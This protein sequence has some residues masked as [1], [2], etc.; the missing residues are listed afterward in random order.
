MTVPAL[1]VRNA[2]WGYAGTPVV[3]VSEL[4]LSAGALCAV[5][6]ANGAGKSTLLSGLALLR[7]PL[8]GEVMVGGDPAWPQL[9]GADPGL[10]A[11]RRRVTLL[12]Q[13]PA[14][15]ST[16]VRANVAYGLRARGIPREEAHR[17]A[18]A[19]L[20]LMGLIELARRPARSLS[21]GET[22][23]M[24]IARAFVLGTPVLLLDE[25]F[26]SLDAA[27]R[28][29]LRELIAERRA[30]GTAVIVATHVGELDGLDID[31]VLEL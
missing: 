20:E 13:R 17:R 22:Q 5:V 16:D 18:D 7:P 29:L 30:A 15:F 26:S 1:Q 27:T 12:H 19:A 6:G 9:K 8:R 4:E 24:V 11:L 2:A 3:E 28:P 14:V 31:R 21:G 25:P 10:L 23:R